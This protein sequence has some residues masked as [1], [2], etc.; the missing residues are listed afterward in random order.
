[1]NAVCC[2]LSS[3]WVALFLDSVFPS[4]STDQMSAERLRRVP[5]R[6]LEFSFCESLSPKELCPVLAPSVF[7]DSQLCLQLRKFTGC[8]VGFPSLPTP[9][10]GS[11]FKTDTR[12]IIDFPSSLHHLVPTV[13]QS[14]VSYIL[15]AISVVLTGG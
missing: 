4:A 1:M 14:I 8:Y 12:K 10:P 2:S 6:L 5:C 7:L 9:W 13:F 15:S 3:F 11:S